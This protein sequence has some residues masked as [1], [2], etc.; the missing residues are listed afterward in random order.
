LGR[1]RAMKDGGMGQGMERE[2]EVDRVGLP[3]L[4]PVGTR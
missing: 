2:A 1:A 4:G 3:L